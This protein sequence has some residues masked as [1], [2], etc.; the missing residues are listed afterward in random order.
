MGVRVVAEAR[1]PGEFRKGWREG[2]TALGE[3][4]R[5][6]RPGHVIYPRDVTFQ[7]EGGGH[8]RRAEVEREVQKGFCTGASLAS[9]QLIRRQGRDRP[10][11]A[12]MALAA[13]LAFQGQLYKLPRIA[14]RQRKFPG[15]CAFT[16]FNF[17][18]IKESRG[19]Q[20]SES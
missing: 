5:R 6:G 9:G 7:K 1:G 16:L 19:S 4:H 20:R 3:G 17:R 15:F 14:K 11:T 13:H 12:S 2:R 18:R 8:Q 10:A